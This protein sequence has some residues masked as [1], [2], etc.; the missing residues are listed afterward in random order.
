MANVRRTGALLALVVALM[1]PTAR[2]EQQQPPAAPGAAAPPATPEGQQP[3]FRTGVNF[4]RVDAIV[5][6]SKGNIVKD[7]KAE[8]FEIYE[9]GE[10]Q[11]I[12]NFSFVSSVRETSE[13]VKNPN[14]KFTVPVPTAELKA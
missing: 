7:L 3:T 9:N 5:T 2:A 6:D 11:K 1:L 14:E 13:T 12:S 8:D 4:V 10:K